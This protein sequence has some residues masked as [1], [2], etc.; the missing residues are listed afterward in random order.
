MCDTT[1]MI[2]LPIRARDFFYAKINI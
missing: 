2:S 1:F